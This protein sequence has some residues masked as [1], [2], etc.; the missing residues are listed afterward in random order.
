MDTSMA[1]ATGLVAAL[2]L[3]PPF[4]AVVAC[5]DLAQDNACQ[6]IATAINEKQPSTRLVSNSKYSK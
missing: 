5:G 3:D 1:Q 4:P 2:H 6:P